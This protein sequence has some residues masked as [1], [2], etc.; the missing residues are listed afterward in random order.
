MLCAAVSLLFGKVLFCFAMTMLIFSPE[1][2]KEREN[3][4]GCDSIGQYG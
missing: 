2:K 4:G 3:R 1:K